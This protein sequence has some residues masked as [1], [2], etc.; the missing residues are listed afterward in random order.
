M[1]LYTVNSGTTA[2]AASG[3]AKVAIQIATPSGVTAKLVGLSISFNGNDA[4]KTPAVVEVCRETGVSSGGASGTLNQVGGGATRT[5]QSTARINDTTDG[6][7]PTVLDGWLISPTSAF[8]YQWPLGREVEIT[9]GSWL[10]IRVT[11]GSAGSAVSYNATAYVE[12]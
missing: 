11:A 4:S 2:E 1:A 3:T 7:S 5:V 12:E 8:A 10:A 9:A 6:A